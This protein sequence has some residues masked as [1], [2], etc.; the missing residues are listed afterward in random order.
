MLWLPASGVVSSVLDL[1]TR[2]WVRSDMLGKA[3][4]ASQLIKLFLS[5]VMVYAALAPFGCLGLLIFWAM[6]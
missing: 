4:L 5:L 6:A 1:L 2:N 3:A